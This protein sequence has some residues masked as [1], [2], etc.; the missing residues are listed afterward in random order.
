MIG[1][2]TMVMKDGMKIRGDINVAL[3]VLFLK[4]IKIYIINREIQVLQKV[5]Y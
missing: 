3:I 4:I 2:N 1:G 5:N